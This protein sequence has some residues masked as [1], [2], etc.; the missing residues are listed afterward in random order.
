MTEKTRKSVTIDED[1][2]EW[3]ENRNINFSGLVNDL[4]NQ[5]RATNESDLSVLKRRIKEEQ[6]EVAELREKIDRK[7]TN[8]RKLENEL[9][10]REE[11]EEEKKNLLREARDALEDTPLNRENPAV[12]NWARK[13]EMKPVKLVEELSDEEEA[14]NGHRNTPLKSGSGLVVE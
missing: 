1:L 7:E 14:T 6:E 13:L 2:A 5:Y 8:L 3:V 4:L 9:E 10:Q 12:K 11:K